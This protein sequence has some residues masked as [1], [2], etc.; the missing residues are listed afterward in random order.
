MKNKVIKILAIILFL[1]LIVF[2]LTRIKGSKKQFKTV[3]L[4]E[5]NLV[6]N[7]V[8]PSYYDTILIVG[9][10]LMGL[11]NESV[12]IRKLSESAKSQFDG[13]LQAHLKYHEGVFYLFMND[14]DREESIKILAHEIIH[15]QQY[16]SGDL[17]YEK[18][19]MTWMG[20]T[21]D[22]NSQPYEMRPWENDAFDRARA[23]SNNIESVLVENN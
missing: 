3:V 16:S 17:K 6:N 2:L 9:M 18:G 8:N 20:N 15:I 13:E 5:T 22:L 19:L 12:V 7:V 14:H 4:S 21:T 10:D 23:L 1:T 11:K